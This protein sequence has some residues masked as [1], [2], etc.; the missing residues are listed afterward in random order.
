MEP[1]EQ[2]DHWS[3]VVVFFVM[4]KTLSVE[5]SCRWTGLVMCPNIKACY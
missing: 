4:V 3:S 1:G 2:Q 5:L